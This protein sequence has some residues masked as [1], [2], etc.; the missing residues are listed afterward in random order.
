MKYFKS[1]IILFITFTCIVYSQFQPQWER[2]W[3][4]TQDI[5]TVSF[6]EMDPEGN[7]VVMG[8]TYI[9]TAGTYK[10]FVLKY[11][12]NGDLIWGN[13]YTVNELDNP[14]GMH[15]DQD[16]YIYIGMT[17]SNHPTQQGFTLVKLRS[18][19][20][21]NFIKRYTYSPGNN[22]VSYDTQHYLK[23]AYGYSYISGV[24]HKT[25]WR[26]KFGAQGEVHDSVYS[27]VPADPLDDIASGG[28]YAMIDPATQYIYQGVSTWD[29]NSLGNKRVGIVCMNSTGM[30]AWKTNLF[31]IPDYMNGWISKIVKT[32]DG[33]IIVLSWISKSGTGPEFQRVAISKLNP[34][35][36]IL[37][38]NIYQGTADDQWQSATDT[39]LD[40]GENVIVT[41]QNDRFYLAK[42]NQA[43]EQQWLKTDTILIRGLRL[44]TDADYNV[45]VA[46]LDNQGNVQLIRFNRDGQE[47]YRHQISGISSQRPSEINQILSAGSGKY[48]LAG[49]KHAGIHPNMDTYLLSVTDPATTIRNEATPKGF[50]LTQNFPNPFNPTTTIHY[51]ITEESLVKLIVYDM[52]GQI[53]RTLV[54]GKETAGTHVVPFDAAGLPSGVY[55][56]VLTVSSPTG[57][58]SD[59]IKMNL[60][61]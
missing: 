17:V 49:G 46:A 7:L 54:D 55:F 45:F 21:V 39:R 27:F 9:P 50:T 11:A 14:I 48:Y 1:T 12:P 10:L 53:V 56:G 44:M 25:A 22:N 2:T 52:L 6:L 33:N 51:S 24:N 42:I 20:S 57:T 37:W 18:D 35:G 60:I 32:S 29:I 16:K 4:T 15:I 30:F 3:G 40:A 8:T 36:D 23:D 41:G 43:G 61:K 19:G 58:S 26:M 5:E 28:H 38:H 13:N 59:L 47:M 31:T 34:G